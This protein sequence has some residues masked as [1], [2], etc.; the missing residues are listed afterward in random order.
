MDYTSV[1]HHVMPVVLA[2]LTGVACLVIVLFGA[3]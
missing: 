1:W 2:V 3:A